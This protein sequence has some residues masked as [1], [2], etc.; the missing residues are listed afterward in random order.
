VGCLGVHFGL[1]QAD[2]EKLPSFKDDSA[3]L[4]YLQEDLKETEQAFEYTWQWFQEVRRMWLRAA[5]EDRY[6]LFTADQ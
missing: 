4:E 2:V 6:V 1:S 3:R 5:S